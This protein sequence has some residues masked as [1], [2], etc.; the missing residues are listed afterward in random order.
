MIGGCDFAEDP[1]LDARTARPIW[2]CTCDLRIDADDD[3]AAA[4]FSLWKIAGSKS[5]WHDGATLSVIAEIDQQTVRLTLDAGVRDGTSFAF[6][7][8]ARADAHTAW[9][10]LSNLLQSSR[11]TSRSTRTAERHRPSRSSIVH[12]RALQA[13]D[14]AAVGASHREIAEVIFGS[15]DVFERW[16]TDSELRAQIRY[17]VRRGQSL[18]NGGYR[19]LLN[20]ST[21]ARENCETRSILPDSRDSPLNLSLPGHIPQ[22]DE[23][24]SANGHDHADTH[25]GVPHM[26]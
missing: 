1:S 2:S 9:L 10:L 25:H 15:R 8:P 18:V 26:R 23:G 17:L 24:D 21:R 7:V 11:A 19:Q 16:H 5:V 6:H 14:G 12:L 3:P 13:V 4:P 20:P 22:A